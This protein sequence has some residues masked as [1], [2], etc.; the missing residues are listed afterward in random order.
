MYFSC[1][2]FP[3][4]SGRP[5]KELIVLF[6][7]FQENTQG[8][9]KLSDLLK[10]TELISGGA[11]I[12]IQVGLTPKPRLLNG[13]LPFTTFHVICICSYLRPPTL[14]PEFHQNY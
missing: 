14:T 1:I 4:A 9:E 2:I 3:Q 8:S 11:N 12:Q 5:C 10:V 6:S 13:S 7:I